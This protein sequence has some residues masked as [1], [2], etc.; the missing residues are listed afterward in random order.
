M[1]VLAA[2]LL[3]L[4]RVMGW[5]HS[6]LFC[7]RGKTLSFLHPPAQPNT[8]A[9]ILPPQPSGKERLCVALDLVGW[10]EPADHFD[11]ILGT[12]GRPSLTL[13]ALLIAG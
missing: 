5:L 11:E 1:V 7:I 10:Q 8:A 9:A 6:S 13:A 2:I 12:I 3:V 4:Q